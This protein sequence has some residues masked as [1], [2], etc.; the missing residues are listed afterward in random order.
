MD[1]RAA[2]KAL[3][4]E[5]SGRNQVNCPGPFHSVKDRSLSVLFDR[6]SPDG[7]V[8]RCYSNN[9]DPL[10][11]R[12]YV[13]QRLGLPAWRPIHG[14]SK[15]TPARILRKA[16]PLSGAGDQRADADRARI[17][18]A[19]KLWGEG[20][21]PRG[22][23]AEA[24]LRSRAIRLTADLSGS[25]L[26]FHPN[27]PWRDEDSGITRFIPALLAAFRSIIDDAITAVHRMRLDQP[28]RWPK[29]ERRMLGIVGGAAVKLGTPQGASLVIGEGVETSIAAQQLGISPAWAL[30]GVA[31]I[32]NFPVLP[33]I[34]TLTILAE[35]G[36]P[37]ERAIQACG[38]RWHQ[39][40]R[41]VRIV[42]PDVGSD[43]NDVLIASTQ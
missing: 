22:T 14:R 17:E 43:M 1:L 12:D 19:V 34:E 30:G 20:D 31:A 7:F 23:P 25:V 39:V 15:A 6:D 5:I 24:Y 32:S 3:G 36:A 33:D 38:R 21:D 26:R 16:T 11:C 41:R 28:D 29:I 27:C 13:R 18:R 4:G 10:I 9:D 42:R 35:V 40:G 2:A 8:V 37:S